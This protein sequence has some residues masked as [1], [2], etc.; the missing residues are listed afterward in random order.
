MI[1]RLR[2]CRLSIVRN[3]CTTSSFDIGADLVSSFGERKREI[4]KE[5]KIQ[6]HV[7][8]E[9]ITFLLT[10]NCGILFET[11]FPVS[12]RAP[13]GAHPHVAHADG[14]RVSPFH[15]DGTALTAR[16]DRDE[17]LEPRNRE[18]LVLTLAEQI[19]RVHAH[20]D[21]FGKFAT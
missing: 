1:S 9:I 12:G 2:Q 19:R 3:Y 13:T 6:R 17:A 4:E 21:E 8:R 7:Q 18:P 11:E 15:E 10:G 14:I 20:L 16:S 5:K